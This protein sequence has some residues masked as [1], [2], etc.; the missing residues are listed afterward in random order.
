LNAF[1]EDFFI[2][3][4]ELNLPEIETPEETMERRAR[5]NL[6]KIEAE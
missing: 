1:K 3:K 4:P 2:E 5:E 6:E